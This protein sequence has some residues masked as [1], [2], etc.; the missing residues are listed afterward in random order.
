MGEGPAPIRSLIAGKP[1]PR[2]L[3]HSI[4]QFDGVLL[5]RYRLYVSAW[6]RQ[7]VRMTCPL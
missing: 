7:V 4:P 3:A 1:C 6:P 2:Q 5:D